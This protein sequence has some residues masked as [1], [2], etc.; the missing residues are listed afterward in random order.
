MNEWLS[1]SHSVIHSFIHSFIFACM[2]SFIHWLFHAI[3]PFIH[4]DFHWFVASLVLFDLV[5]LHCI[6]SFLHSYIDASYQQLMR[7]VMHSKSFLA[8]AIA[9]LA[10]RL[11]SETSA[12]ARPGT[13]GFQPWCHAQPTA[14]HPAQLGLPPNV[15][16]DSPVFEIPRAG[17]KL[18]W[19]DQNNVE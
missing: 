9:F 6:P 17:W 8:K 11:F 15:W 19:R 1:F 12:T 4:A 13:A 2:H 16:L 10:R 3:H 14:M 18:S 7:Y 5:P